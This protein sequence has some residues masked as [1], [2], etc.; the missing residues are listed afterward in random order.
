MELLAWNTHQK[1]T[2]P[3]KNQVKAFGRCVIERVEKES[4]SASM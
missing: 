1:Y 2:E 3:E 4:L